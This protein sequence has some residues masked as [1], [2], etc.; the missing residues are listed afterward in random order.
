MNEIGELFQTSRETSGLSLEEV[1]K[2]LN[3]KVEMLENIED[4][5]VGAFKDIY[6][7]KEYLSTYAKYLGIDATK[8]IDEFNEYMFEYTSR[9]PIKEI[10]KTI[11]LKIKEEEKEEKI[12]SPY[13]KQSKKYHNYVYVIIYIVILLMVLFVMLWSIK[14]ITVG[15]NETHEISY[16]K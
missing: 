4:G 7:L 2:D 14:Q 1:S 5:R 15:Q 13:T 3:I 12:A 10:E 8:I 9:I 16:R 6:E 11:E